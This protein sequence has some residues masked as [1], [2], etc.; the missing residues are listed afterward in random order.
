MKYDDSS[1]FL[2]LLYFVRINIWLKD[3]CYTIF[4][5]SISMETKD[6]FLKTDQNLCL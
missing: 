1:L 5:V 3:F 4:K 2:N 6:S